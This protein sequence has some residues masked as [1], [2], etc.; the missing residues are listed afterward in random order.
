MDWL[1]DR[2]F[3][4]L[5]ECGTL[6]VVTAN[7]TTFTYGNHDRPSVGIKFTSL[8]WQTAVLLDPE[9]RVGE[10]YM[11][12]GLVVEEGSIADFL[13][14]MLVNL[15]LKSLPQWGMPWAQVLKKLRRVARQII[16][17]NNP[18]RAE[19]NA[20]YHYD[21]DER[22][23]RLFLDTDMQYSCAYFEDDGYSLDQAQE[24]KKRHIARK[25]HLTRDRLRVLDI[26]SGWGGL[27]LHLAQAHGAAV[28]GINLSDEQ[29]RVSGQRALAT[30]AT[31]RFEKHDYREITG[32]FDRIVSVGMFEHVGQHDHAT[33]LRKCYD[34]LDDDGV[35]PLHT[36]GR[37]DGPAET[38]EWVWKYIFPGG[39]APALSELTPLLEKTG[40]IIA[41]I[42]ILRLHYAE[43]LKHWR[44]RILANRAEALRIADS[45]SFRHFVKGETFL[46]M[47]E[48]YLAGFEAS[49][50]HY[51]LSVFQI[52]LSKRIDAVPITRDYLYATEA[53][54]LP[55]QRQR[56]LR[57]VDRAG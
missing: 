54:P 4:R 53:M 1:L 44:E 31:C 32:K 55:A 51:G 29:L 43:T 28:L 11:H 12:G 21:I 45:P 6:R 30:G 37:W 57:I 17:I 46:R 22:M 18:R 49:F 34:L 25:L 48:W 41:D 52:Q 35:M 27:G 10:A 2:F 15:R 26:G 9:L 14:L 23:Y 50:R 47:W 19:T 38:N 42:E 20:R 5:I 56:A 13:D 24:A 39:Y 8:A 36:V 3:R 7:G 40:F 16:R 33:F